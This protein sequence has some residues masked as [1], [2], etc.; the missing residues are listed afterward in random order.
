MVEHSMKIKLFLEFLAFSAA[1]VIAGPAE[2]RVD[3][4]S[5]SLQQR[6]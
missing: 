2:A 4:D 3:Y 5:L 1:A 6:T